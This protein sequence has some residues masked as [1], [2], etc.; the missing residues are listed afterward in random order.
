MK[1]N[2]T[3]NPKANDI[4][5]EWIIIDATDQILGRLATKIADL[6]RGKG[7]SSYASNVDVG[8]YV[9]VINARK[10]KVTGNK[11]VGKTYFRHTGYPGGARITTLENVLADHPD[12]VI[13]SAVKGMLP[14]NKLQSVYLNKLRVFADES[15]IHEAQSPKAMQI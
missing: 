9:V 13:V 15:H 14:K 8:D 1:N 6:L 4:N 12:R 3:F 11:L 7:K 5:K 2:K 10:I